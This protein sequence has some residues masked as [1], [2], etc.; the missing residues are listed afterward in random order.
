MAAYHSSTFR[1]GSTSTEMLWAQVSELHV[2]NDDIS[3]SWQPL[4]TAWFLWCAHARL[5]ENQ[6]RWR[7]NRVTI[8]LPRHRAPIRPRTYSST[9]VLSASRTIDIRHMHLH[10]KTHM[11]QN[12]LMGLHLSPIIKWFQEEQQMLMQKYTTNTDWHA[13]FTINDS[14]MFYH[15]SLIGNEPDR[16]CVVVYTF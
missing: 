9:L 3:H 11:I 14:K 12:P 15:S 4:M 5:R 13:N 10:I 2:A 1:R 8:E 6:I 7:N 16:K